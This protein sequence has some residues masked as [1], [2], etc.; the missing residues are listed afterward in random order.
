MN[1]E[2]YCSY[3]IARVM[4]Y[5]GFDWD[6]ERAYYDN[7]RNHNHDLVPISVV[8]KAARDCDGTDVYPSCT[9]SQAQKWLREN[10]KIMV[11]PFACI[12]DKTWAYR[13]CQLND[14]KWGMTIV[15]DGKAITVYDFDSYE[16]ALSAGI[17]KALDLI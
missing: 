14:E 6:C 12:S 7:A 3:A 9:L 8:N 10:H 16:Q 13:L 4:Y 5:E 1:H 11:E 2:D 15:K 17:T